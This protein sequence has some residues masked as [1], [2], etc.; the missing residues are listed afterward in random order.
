[1]RKQ[2][3]AAAVIRQPNSPGDV[4]LSQGCKLVEGCDS[5]MIMGK[6]VGHLWQFGLLCLAFQ[7]LPFH[8]Q[9]FQ[10]LIHHFF[11][12]LFTPFLVV[13]IDIGTKLNLFF[14]K[15]YRK[16]CC[17]SAFAMGKRNNSAAVTTVFTFFHQN[18]YGM[19]NSSYFC[20]TRTRQASQRCSN[21]RVVLFLYLWLTEFLFTRMAARSIVEVSNTE[22]NLFLNQY[23]PIPTSSNSTSSFPNSFFT[24]KL[25][26]SS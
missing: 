23:R 19:K 2:A 14:P 1:M 12:K 24:L 20:T 18:T 11:S 5:R 17:S 16:V 7:L 25:G 3:I 13:V 6:Y 4:G 26:S 15:G 8:F 22:Y 9:F 21:V 10:V